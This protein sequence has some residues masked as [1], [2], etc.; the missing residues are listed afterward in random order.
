VVL[1]IESESVKSCVK[2]LFKLLQER[3]NWTIFSYYYKLF[4]AQ[5]Q[6]LI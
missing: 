6:P 3:I 4:E 5:F 1:T 2:V